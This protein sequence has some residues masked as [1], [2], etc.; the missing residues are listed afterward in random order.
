MKTLL[1]ALEA[2]AA[3]LLLALFAMLPLDRASAAGGRLARA[4]GPRL[5]V[6]GIARRNLGRAFPEKS[7]GEIEA[8]V[9]GM[10]DNLGRVAAEYTHLGEFDL[11]DPRGRVEVVGV[12]TIETLRD[13][14][15]GG[16]FFSAHLGNWEIASLVATQ[17]GVPLTQIYRAAN[18]PRMET[19]LRSLRAPVGGSNFPKGAGGAR[20]L[21]KALRRG[22]HLGML[23]DQK[24]NEGI[25][26]PFF[27]RDAMTAPAL[28]Q[29]ARR[30]ACPVAPVRVERLEGAH[31]RLTV[32]PPLTLAESGDREADTAAAMGQVNAIIEGWIRDRPE[33]WLWLHRRWPE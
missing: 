29:L 24:L 8:I 2:A 15:M 27:G 18:N 31:F 28:A 13:D 12:E 23:V 1:Q 10:W 5:A 14:R 21:I 26:V 22:G 16:I 4:V 3:R 32:Y 19:L 25:P 11:T 30:F 17:N 9:R 20:Q 7:A 6:S 33:Q